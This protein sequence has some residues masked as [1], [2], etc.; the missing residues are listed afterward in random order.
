MEGRDDAVAAVDC[1]PELLMLPFMPVALD[2]LEGIAVEDR[3]EY[4][5]ELG[6]NGW[7]ERKAS[8][9]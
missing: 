3:F 9:P 7:L 1:A 5:E 6:R 4:A 8:E 2:A